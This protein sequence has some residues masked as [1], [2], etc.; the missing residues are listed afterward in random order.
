M[1]KIRYQDKF[2]TILILRLIQHS[3]PVGQPQSQPTATATAERARKTWCRAHSCRSTN[4]KRSAVSR[5]RS[6]WRRHTRG[7]C[8]RYSMH[9]VSCARHRM[10]MRT[11]C[12]WHMHGTCTCAVAPGAACCAASSRSLRTRAT[13][14]RVRSACSWLCKCRRALCVGCAPPSSHNGQLARLMQAVAYGV[15]V[16]ER[17][18][19]SS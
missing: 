9:A 2:E 19:P 4:R 1:S 8:M 16:L 7:M 18:G 5:H 14:C 3:E 15:C 6:A 11:A 17:P 10:C 12:A 13:A